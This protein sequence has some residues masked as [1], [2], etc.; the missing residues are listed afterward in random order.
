MK[1]ITDLYTAYHDLMEIEKHLLSFESDRSYFD[2]IRLAHI[3]ANEVS[4]FASNSDNDLFFKL[5]SSLERALGLI[6]NFSIIVNDDI[7]DVLL[8]CVEK[9]ENMIT[10]SIHLGKTKFNMNSL[11]LG[12]KNFYH[13]N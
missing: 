4:K 6:H 12:L 10:N 2:S 9:L 5:A 7:I 1:N 13:D 11:I 8:E 3:Y